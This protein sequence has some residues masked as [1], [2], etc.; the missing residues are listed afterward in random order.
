MTDKLREYIDL[1]EKLEKLKLIKKERVTLVIALNKTNALIKLND[2]KIIT[3][4]KKIEKAFKL[5][6]P[7][8]KLLIEEKNGEEYKKLGRSVCEEWSATFNKEE[9]I[10]NEMYLKSQM[11]SN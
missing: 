10:E 9:E 8:V 7:T 5:S 4:M 3:E 2:N 6:N 11:V 1:G